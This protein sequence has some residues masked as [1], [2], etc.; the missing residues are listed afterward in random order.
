MITILSI[1]ILLNIIFIITLILNSYKTNKIEAEKKKKIQIN[2]Q[3]DREISQKAAKLLE[4]ADKMNNIPENTNY[5]IHGYDVD[6]INKQDIPDN[7][8]SPVNTG[9]LEIT[10]PTEETTEVEMA[11]DFIDL[12]IKNELTSK[13][14][15]PAESKSIAE[16]ATDILKAIDENEKKTKKK[17]I[18]SKTTTKTKKTAPK[19]K[20]TKKVG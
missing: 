11:R 3:I 14:N 1:S 5:G 4:N 6:F 2:E 18:K 17:P 19:T 16:T 9:K 15:T 7:S 8:F 10:E 12:P 13:D 20:K